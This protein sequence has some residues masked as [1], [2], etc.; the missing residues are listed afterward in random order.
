MRRNVSR[1][2]FVHGTLGMGT[3]ALAGCA[4]T[5]TTS[6][7]VTNLAVSSSD[8]TGSEAPEDGSTVFSSGATAEAPMQSAPAETGPR[9][10]DMHADTVDVLGMT[11]YLPYSGFDTKYTGSLVSNDAQ[12]SADRMGNMRWAQCYA[13]WL[14]DIGGTFETELS[15]IE[16]YRA[17]AAWFKTQMTEHPDR[18]AQAR[19]FSDIP[20]ILDSGRVACIFAVENAACL[21][22]GLQV[23]DEFVEDGVL[24]AGVTWN[25]RN[26]LGCGNDHPEEGLTDLGRQYVGALES[27]GIV[28]DV[29]H[30]NDAGFWEVEALATRPYVA[31]HSNARAV[32]NHLR[33]LS[34]EQFAA[35]AARGGLV[36]LNL[37]AGFI[38]EGANDYGFD[39]LAAHV[40]HWLALGGEDIIA[41]GSDRD[42]SAIP[43]WIADC[44]NQVH[45]Y[46]LFCE[47]VGEDITRKL[48]FENALRFFQAYES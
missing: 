48:F 10:F 18:L 44:S 32:C 26:A 5:P 1:R 25:G 8:A 23:V 19:S 3:I 38:A 17:A 36:G 12:V 41:L 15:N 43:A 28:L 29:S 35:I 30:L 47:R 45:L 37:N 42:G 11:D 46:E 33:N 24:I 39:E 27:H 9:C 16:Y 34:D 20:A 13:T 21:D 40:E 14:P 4:G 31:T 2:A 6:T 7:S 22:E